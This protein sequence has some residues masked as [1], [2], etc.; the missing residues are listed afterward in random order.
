[1]NT[2]TA[3]ASVTVFV[4]TMALASSPVLADSITGAASSAGSSASSAGS[5][6]LRGSSDAIGGSSNSSAGQA[7]V[8]AGTY[9]VASVDVPQNRPDKRRLTLQPAQADAGQR[10]FTLTLPR[11]PF[12]EGRLAP[13]DTVAVV[14]RAYGLEFARA[15]DGQPFFLVLAADWEQDLHPRQVK[16]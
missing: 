15:D 13:G 8:T 12:A 3:L 10:E 2:R 6:S 7:Q 5:A 14:R 11:Q 4:M 16:Q 9:R 1:M